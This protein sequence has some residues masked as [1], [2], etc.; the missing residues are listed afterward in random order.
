MDES[1]QKVSEQALYNI[2]YTSFS[3][4][5]FSGKDL[6]ALLRK[7]QANNISHS[8]TEALIYRDGIFFQ[9]IEGPRGG[10]DAVYKKIQSDSRHTSLTT[11]FEGSFQKRI[12]PD[13]DMHY[14]PSEVLDKTWLNSILRAGNHLRDKKHHPDQVLKILEKLRITA[15]E[16]NAS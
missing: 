4:Q 5:P 11:F 8:V 14:V 1:S 3:T 16:H 15:L 12:F 6:M 10:L 9:Y 7:A 13:W 2:A